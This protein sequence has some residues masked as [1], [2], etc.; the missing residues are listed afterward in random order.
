MLKYVK[1][2]NN[3]QLK[4]LKTLSKNVN[5]YIYSTVQCTIICISKCVI[6][7]LIQSTSPNR[8]NTR[9]TKHK[10]VAKTFRKCFPLELFTRSCDDC[11]L[12][13]QTLI[14]QNPKT[15]NCKLAALRYT[16]TS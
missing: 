8:L 15:V 9:K 12:R 7:A 14:S 1:N 10:F 11:S 5:N 16:K 13:L 6:D 3:I 4:T 2:V